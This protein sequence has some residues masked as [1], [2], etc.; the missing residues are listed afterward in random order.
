MNFRISTGT[1]DQE[2]FLHEIM[3]EQK[4]IVFENALILKYIY[5]DRSQ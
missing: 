5:F 3:Q 4:E 2:K 1:V